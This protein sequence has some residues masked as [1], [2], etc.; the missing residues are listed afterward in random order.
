MSVSSY[1]KFLL[2]AHIVFIEKKS[3]V[4]GTCLVSRSFDASL[5]AIYLKT[6]LRVF[7]FFFPTQHAL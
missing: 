3:Q 1:F 2:S 4:V 7:Q 6:R 5:R